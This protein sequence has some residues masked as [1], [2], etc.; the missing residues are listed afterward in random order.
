MPGHQPGYLEGVGRAD[1][2]VL[3]GG[4]ALPVDGQG[5]EPGAFH[6]DEESLAG[7]NVPVQ[8]A[9]DAGG[10]L[11]GRHAGQAGTDALVG[12]VE[13]GVGV[14]VGVPLLAAH[15][16]EADVTLIQRAGNGDRRALPFDGALPGSAQ[17]D[18][19]H[20]EASFHSS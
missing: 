12:L 2:A 8:R 3:Q 16:R 17:V 20:G 14:V 1:G 5:Q 7:G 18:D 10:A 15:V 11:M 19:P 9:G 4:D 13:G 6:V